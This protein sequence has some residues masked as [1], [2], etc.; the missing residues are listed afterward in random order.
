[1]VT[2]KTSS[3]YEYSF[4]ESVCQDWRYI[5]ALKNVRKGT[6]DPGAFIDGA[7]SL[8][9][10]LFNDPE[11]EEEYY[12][13]LAEQ[14]GGRVPSDVVFGEVNEIITAIAEQGGKATKN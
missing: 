2:G 5:K 7:T 9:E 8:V 1:M 14:H 4:D 12:Q 3:G 6:K 11:K 10:I 13:F